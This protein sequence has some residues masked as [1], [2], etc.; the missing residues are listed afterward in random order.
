MNVLVTGA[1]GYIGSHTIVELLAAGHSVTGVDDFSLGRRCAAERIGAVAGQP[2]HIVELD[3][4]SAPGVDALLSIGNFDAIIH[5]AGRKFVGESVDD[6]VLYFDRNI[7]TSIPLFRAAQQ[8]GVRKIVFSS[9]CTVYGN[10]DHLP[11]TEE[12]PLAPVTPYGFTKLAIEQLLSDLC[13]STP[14]LDAIALRYFNPIGA[15]PSGLLGEYV[16]GKPNNL[17]PYIMKVASGELPYFSLFGDDY[18]T[19]DGSCVRD[20]VHVEDIARGHVAAFEA[21]DDGR[22]GFRAINL[23]TGT[24]RSVLEMLEA[25][26]DATQHRI[27]TQ[28]HPRR[29]GDA[30]EIFADPQRAAEEIGWK[31]ERTLKEM[32]QD[33]WNFTVSATKRGRKKDEAISN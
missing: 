2:V 4:R 9:S 33:H 28:V 12:S 31:A 10:P 13:V 14:D 29:D 3:L 11:V 5:L 25:C 26:R 32:C 24:G 8:H 6:P 7:G 30:E 23:G 1:A 22:R 27:P 19:Q 20:Y 18:N 17:L 21:L 16:D 15:H